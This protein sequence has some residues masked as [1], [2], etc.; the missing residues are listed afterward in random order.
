[1]MMNF[2]LSLINIRNEIKIVVCVLVYLMCVRVCACLHSVTSVEQ[3]LYIFANWS[4]YHAERI[5]ST[6]VASRWYSRSRIPSVPPPQESVPNKGPY[7]EYWVDRRD[8]RNSG[9]KT[10][11]KMFIQIFYLKYSVWYS[12]WVKCAI[13]SKCGTRCYS[14]RVACVVVQH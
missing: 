14:V 1:M 12:H 5:S 9:I 8:S 13:K 6:S 11:K 7:D 10:R 2:Y 3:V 4:N